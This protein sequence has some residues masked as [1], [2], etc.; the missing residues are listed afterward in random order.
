MTGRE[1]VDFSQFT[2]P[3]LLKSLDRI[4]RDLYPEI[5][6]ACLSEIE[7]RRKGGLWNVPVP[8]KRQVTDLLTP[9]WFAV[10]MAIRLVVSFYLLTVTSFSLAAITLI[11]PYLGMAVLI[12]LR[13]RWALWF[14]V[15][16]NGIWVLIGLLAWPSFGH[17]HGGDIYV[18]PAFPGAIEIFVG[19]YCLSW[20]KR[21]PHPYERA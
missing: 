5:Y 9:F 14:T 3:G 17:L 19:A 10:P 11:L 13:V 12:F 1:K 20:M 2:C 7:S 18:L 21:H 8:L 15:I 6:W 16:S 4:D